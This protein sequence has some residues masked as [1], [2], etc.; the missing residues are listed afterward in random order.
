MVVN[1]TELKRG[2][3]LEI[4]GDPWQATEVQ[5]QTP[6]A[7]GASL[8]VKAKVKNL[9]TG[10]TLAKTWRRRR[11]RDH[12]GGGLPPGAVPLPPGGRLRL[13]GP[14]SYEQTTLD[15]GKVGDAPATCSRTS[16]CKTVFFQERVIALNLPLSVDLLVE[17]TMPAIKGAT[18][19]AQLKPAKVETG[20]TVMVPSYI[21]AGE[22]IRVDTRDG[23]FVERAKRSPGAHVPRNAGPARSERIWADRQPRSRKAARKADLR[24]GLSRTATNADSLG[25]RA[26]G[27]ADGTLHVRD[28]GVAELAAL[29]LASRPSIRRA[30]S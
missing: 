27:A 9:R 22:K 5:S 8:L 20:I 12:G 25:A 1:V 19:Q 24:R 28:D 7:R 15:V 13:H 3:I 11:D 4:D 14:R 23:R 21:E 10:Q 17:D 26:A 2:D 30:K 16:R 6:S 29:H 18:A